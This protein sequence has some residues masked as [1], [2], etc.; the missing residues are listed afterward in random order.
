MEK[1]FNEKIYELASSRNAGRTA[2]KAINSYFGNGLTDEIDPKEFGKLTLE[3][4]AKITGI[5][6]KSF[7]LLCQAYREFVA[8]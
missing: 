4:L 3:K 5:G 1:S 8:K 7:V 6:T 2:I